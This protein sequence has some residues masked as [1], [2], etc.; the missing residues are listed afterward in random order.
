VGGSVHRRH[1]GQCHSWAGSP[2]RCKRGL[3][4]LQN[5]P[6]SNSVSGQVLQPGSCKLRDE[7]NL[8]PRH[9]LFMGFLTAIESKPGQSY[10]YRCVAPPCPA[11]HRHALGQEEPTASPFVPC[12]LSWALGWWSA[13][14]HLLVPGLGC[15]HR[16]AS[17][18]Y[19][20]SLLLS[21]SQ[22][23]VGVGGTG[24][25]T[26]SALVWCGL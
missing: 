23:R 21:P 22:T 1:C 2:G 18:T 7:I 3:Q 6:V 20:L 4:Q 16:P 25:S 13:L 17:H 11:P 24:L 14:A 5:K 9:A 26:L 19:L 12:R 15:G 8:S 10:S